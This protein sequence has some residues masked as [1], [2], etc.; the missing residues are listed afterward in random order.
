M[1][2]DMGSRQRVQNCEDQNVCFCGCDIPGNHRPRF[3]NRKQRIEK[4]EN[5]LDNLRNEAKAVEEHISQ[6]MKE[7]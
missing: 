2:C 4:L 3:M 5:Y 6:I 7:K 1:C